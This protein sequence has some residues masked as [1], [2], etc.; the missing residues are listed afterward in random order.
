[1]VFKEDKITNLIMEEQRQWQLLVAALDAHSGRE[2]RHTSGQLCSSK[3]VYAHLAA[4]LEFANQKLLNYIRGYGIMNQE[5]SVDESTSIW[6]NRDSQISL[7][8]ARQKAHQIF[9]ERIKILRSIPPEK[10]DFKL[11]KLVAC[12]GAEHYSS[13]RNYI[14][15]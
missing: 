7:T 14:H 12:D 13:H 2:H 11:E 4:W 5:T 6:R 3:D 1:M 8:A 9:A 15:A 10:W